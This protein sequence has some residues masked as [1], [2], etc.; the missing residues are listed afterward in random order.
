MA[1][2]RITEDSRVPWENW[3]ERSGKR[4]SAA[5]A[6][7]RGISAVMIDTATMPCAIMKI[8]KALL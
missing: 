1:G 2:I 8:K 7:I 3:W 5:A 4:L 6:D